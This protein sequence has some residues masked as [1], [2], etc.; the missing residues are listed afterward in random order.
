MSDAVSIVINHRLGKAEAL[1]RLRDG[2]ARGSGHLGPM[3]AVEQ[4][5]WEDDTLLLRLRA[6]G[7]P[8]SARIEVLEDTM[9]IEVSLPWL[10]AAA[11]KRL[12]P[13]LRREAS[14]L[15]EKK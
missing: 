11:A 3:L 7:Q 9:R 10:L 1:R 12:L 14:L 6:L 2:M 8:A 13:V 5:S 15:L 4:E